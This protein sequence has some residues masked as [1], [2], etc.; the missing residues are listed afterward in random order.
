MMRMSLPISVARVYRVASILRFGSALP[1]EG[2]DRKANNDKGKTI[3]QNTTEKVQ[4]RTTDSK[5]HMCSLL[6]HV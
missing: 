6:I 1:P 3:K 5:P 4:K 2:Q